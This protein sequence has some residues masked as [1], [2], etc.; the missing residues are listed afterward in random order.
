MEWPNRF[1]L[2]V[3]C[4]GVAG[5]FVP[6]LIPRIRLVFVI[7]FIPVLAATGCWINYELY[8][9][10]I[11]RPGDPLIRVDLLV[12]VPLLLVAGLSTLVS[13]TVKRPREPKA[14]S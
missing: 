9:R 2:V 4:L 12:I 8:L 13:N 11:A 7:R 3:L 6:W 5:I 1:L 14:Q 10:S